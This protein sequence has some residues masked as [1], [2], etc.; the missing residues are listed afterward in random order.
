MVHK[1]ES[2]LVLTK[3]DMVGSS[4]SIQRFTR[5]PTAHW[6]FRSKSRFSLKLFSVLLEIRLKPGLPKKR[7]IK[8]FNLV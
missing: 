8:D 6:F 2:N 3:K 4:A 5:L 1:T 7:L